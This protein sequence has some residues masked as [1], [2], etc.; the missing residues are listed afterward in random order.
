[1]PVG[2]TI[3]QTQLAFIEALGVDVKPDTSCF[4]PERIIFIS[5]IAEEIFR[6]PQWYALL[7]EDE[8]TE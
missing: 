8:V 7:P 3:Q 2:M 6:S 5:G 4:S 1:M